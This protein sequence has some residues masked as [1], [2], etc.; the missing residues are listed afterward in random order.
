MSR[1][2]VTGADRR[3]IN[4]NIRSGL[5]SAAREA[6]INFSAT[7]ERA[8]TEELAA[9]KRRQWRRDNREAINAYNEHVAKHGMFSDDLRLF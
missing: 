9:I 8:L 2:R 6:G 7:L 1:R 3:T 5:L 4:V